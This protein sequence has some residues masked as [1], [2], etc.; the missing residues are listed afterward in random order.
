MWGAVLHLPAE[1]GQ[2]TGGGEGGVGGEAGWGSRA[3]AGGDAGER[4]VSVR[5]L[6]GRWRVDSRLRGAFGH[7]GLVGVTQHLG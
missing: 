7:R 2:F 4:S 6:G 1:A 5:G 3:F